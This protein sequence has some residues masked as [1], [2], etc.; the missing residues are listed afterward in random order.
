M[1]LKWTRLGSGAIFCQRYHAQYLVV[2]T[3]TGRVCV[4][5]RNGQMLKQC[6]HAMGK[7][8]IMAL[9]KVNF[10]A[11]CGVDGRMTRGSRPCRLA[12]TVHQYIKSVNTVALEP[13]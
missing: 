1:A 5:D 10:F 13:V 11:T 3:N 7:S 4:F 2:G 8:M 12:P 6:A 9:R